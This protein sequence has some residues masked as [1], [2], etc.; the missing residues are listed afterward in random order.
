MQRF[1]P[2]AAF[3]TLLLSH[4]AFASDTVFAL[5]EAPCYNGPSKDSGRFFYVP[6]ATKPLTLNKNDKY[7]VVETRGAWSHVQLFPSSISDK[8]AWVESK[9]LSSARSESTERDIAS[10]RLN[11]FDSLQRE[12]R[13]HL[14]YAG[15]SQQGTRLTFFVTDYW[16]SMSKD[17]REVFVKQSFVRFFAMGGPRNIK[18]KSEDFQ[19]EVRHKDSDRVVATWDS[20]FGLRLKD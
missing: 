13:W 15:V 18:E 10:E 16:N 3:A 12:D 19:I 7:E 1:I 6:T 11:T 4:G 8:T 17:L 14:V 9:H 20:L 5:S 2:L